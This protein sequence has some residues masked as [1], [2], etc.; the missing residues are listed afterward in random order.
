MKPT[1]FLLPFVLLLL[2]SPCIDAAAS[3]TL[4]VGAASVDVTG[5]PGPDMGG[6]L[7]RVQPSTSI[8]THL[9]ARAVYL[10]NEP[11]T[12]VWIAVDSLGFAP[13][14]NTRI[15]TILAG[16]FGIEPW[17]IVI[18]ATHTHSAPVASR[19][20][21]CGEYSEKY[22][23]SVLVP[24]LLQAARDAKASVEECSMVTATGEIELAIDRRN[25]P[26][27]NIEKRVPAVGFKRA[28]GSFKTVLLGYT[29]HPVCYCSGAIA[30]EWPG[31][32]AETVREIFPGK[33][34][35]FVFQG[36]CGNNNPPKRDIPDEEMQS[37][38]KMIVASVADQL[39]SAEP[40]KIAFA[41]RSRHVAMLLDYPDEKGIRE[42]AELHRKGLAGSPKGLAACDAWEQWATQ[43]RNNGGPDFREAE[44]AA[45]VLGDRVFV[46]GPFETHSW[47]NPELIQR[48]SKDCFAVGYTNGCYGYLPHDAAYDEGGYE[49]AAHLWYRNFRFKR[50]E[51][52][53]LAETSAS[54][55]HQAFEA[56]K[57]IECAQF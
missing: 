27:K 25:Q 16:E 47:M 32:A 29:M 4:R 10:E 7:A 49:V 9:F 37:W 28:D 14:I 15:K 3:E 26:T 55:V 1:F 38:G 22:V 23:E 41:V 2:L 12:L 36:A 13:E 52:E 5:E 39:K 24:G 54:L 46:T 57:G 11:E 56:A 30:A 33:T 21:S 17:R 8:R 53:R 34:E 51:L 42:F 19:L 44:I 20:S 31:A 48:T 6:F 40:Q 45:I 50:G 18:S 35:P 43:Y